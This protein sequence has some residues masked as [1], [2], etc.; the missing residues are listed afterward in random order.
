MLFLFVSVITVGLSLCGTGSL[1]S[2]VFGYSSPR[3]PWIY[4]WIGLFAAGSLVML[5]SLFTPI[6]LAS[7]I[8]FFIIGA[9]GL[10]LFCSECKRT[11]AQ[12]KKVEIEIFICFAFL[13]AVVITFY[14][15]RTAWNFSMDT[16]LYHAQ[17]IRWY[18]E[19][20]TP[21][22]LGNLHS[23]LAFNSS[24]LS[25]A[26]LFD[27]G[28]WDGRSA[29]IMPVLSLLG[30]TLYF[31]HELVFSR[32]NGVR[33]YALCIL[34]WICLKLAFSPAAPNLYYDAPV[35]ALNAVIVLEAFYLLSGYAGNL[36]GKETYNAAVLTALGAGAFMIKPIG[37][38]SLLFSGLLALY[39]LARVK[40]AVSSWLIVF[41]PALCALAVWVTKNLF[42]SGYPLYPLPLFAMPF[43]WTMPFGP[44]NGNY[45]DILAWARMPG[46]GYRQSLENGFLYWFNP[47]LTV[48]LK[49]RAFAALAVFPSFLSIIFW[50][51]VVR[52]KKNTKSFYFLA[53]GLFSI[54]Y[55]FQ[56]APDLRFGDG[57]FWVWLGT[58]FLFLAPGSFFFKMAD[59]MKNARIRVAFLCFAV[60]TVICCCVLL[61][62]QV[63]NFIIGLG[64]RV[65]G[66]GLRERDKWMKAQLNFSLFAIVCLAVF[67][68]LLFRKTLLRV[69]VLGSAL[70]FLNMYRKKVFIFIVVLG[71]IGFTAASPERDLLVIGT[72]P[73]RP[74]KEYT[75][76]A[77]PPYNV[78][79]PL[80]PEDNCTGNSPLPS[81]PYPPDNSLEMREPGNA[82]KGFRVLQR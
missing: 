82:G 18:N 75:V 20:G 58:A 70:G 28:I 29:W 73:S 34:V 43:D 5:V 79:I 2:R 16:D 45:L 42:L 74:V 23:R 22:G 19:Y 35:H 62:P 40:Q 44:V 12:C 53:W 76:G 68:T 31:L 11:A 25:L 14:G 21:P 24:W 4:F 80:D 26:A 52:N 67:V 17:V 39:V 3:N 10:P 77:N 36:S 37:A 61:F 56:T 1:T 63:R 51:F 46:P 71:G 55:W 15:A 9:A 60:F 50:F 33:L 66:R 41:A 65:L 30:G 38:V 72:I 6:N 8:I 48:N 78:W 64:E 7:L 57:F 81:A 69:P 47:W 13:A 59:T 27:N 54:A 32:R 49:S